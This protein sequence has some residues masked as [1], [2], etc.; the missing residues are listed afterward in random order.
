ME[1]VLKQARQGKAQCINESMIYLKITGVVGRSKAEKENREFWDL[2]LL[3]Y[4]E[5][6]MKDFLVKWHLGR[7]LREIRE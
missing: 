4:G 7:N 3:F 6:S 5:Q 1:L 2:G